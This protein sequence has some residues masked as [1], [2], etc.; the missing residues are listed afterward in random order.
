MLDVA[1]SNIVLSNSHSQVGAGFVLETIPAQRG[2]KIIK[3]KAC[4][5][6]CVAGGIYSEVLILSNSSL[7]Q[8]KVTYA[9]TRQCCS[10]NI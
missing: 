5:C 1:K 3:N 7:H 4:V 10:E 9:L 2:E 8:T 6:V